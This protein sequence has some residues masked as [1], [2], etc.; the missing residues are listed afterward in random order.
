M[1]LIHDIGEQ[2]RKAF[3]A[4]EFLENVTPRRR[5]ARSPLES[6]T[7]LS[8]RHR[9]CRCAR[10]R[11]CLEPSC[12]TA[13]LNRPISSSPN[14]A[15]PRTFAVGLARKSI[16]RAAA[17]SSSGPE[18]P[19]LEDRDLTTGGSTTPRRSHACLRSRWRSRWMLTLDLF[20]FGAVLYEMATGHLWLPRKANV[21]GDVR[22]HHA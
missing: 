10:R 2:D 11:T 3:I 21:R 13:T 19:T 14:A 22:R 12:I 4:I 15:T 8:A 5:I 7:L 17:P 16:S 9:S 20:S 1:L 18:D 6:E